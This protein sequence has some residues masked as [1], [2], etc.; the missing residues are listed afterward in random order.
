[1]DLTIESIQ[2]LDDRITTLEQNLYD[3]SC[4]VERLLDT[5]TKRR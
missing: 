5:L 2:Q 4:S 3:L 1:M